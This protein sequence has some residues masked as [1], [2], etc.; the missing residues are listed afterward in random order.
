M[1][2]PLAVALTLSLGAC[3]EAPPASPGPEATVQAIHAAWVSGDLASMHQHVD[4][5]QRLADEL[6]PIWDEA[7]EADRADAVARM[8]ALFELSTEK[9]WNDRV[10]GRAQRLT[11]RYEAPDIAWVR[12][13]AVPV[14]G[15]AA[16][17]DAGAPPRF[18]WQY[19]VH[20]REGRWTVTQRELAL[21]FARSDTSDFFRQV[22]RRVEAEFGR[23][24]TLAELNANLPSWVGRLNRKVYRVEALPPAKPR[25]RSP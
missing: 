24:P 10:A 19:R 5:R 7:P 6:G 1:F 11:V 20:A 3:L 23:R 14:A 12:V 21:G 9:Y 13:E 25:P 18:S 15:V 4:Y 16:A 17:E 22:V 2:A 8:Q